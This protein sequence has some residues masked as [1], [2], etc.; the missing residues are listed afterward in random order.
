MKII[1]MERRYSMT[2]ENKVNNT[3]QYRGNSEL[4]KKVRETNKNAG[5]ES[6]DRKLGPDQENLR[7]ITDE[8]DEN[9][10][11]GV[12]ARRTRADFSENPSED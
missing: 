12:E 2:D 1:D 4:D 8:A 6:L 10:N 3:N 5:G 7:S 9:S 11:V